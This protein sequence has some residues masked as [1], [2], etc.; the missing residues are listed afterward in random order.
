MNADRRIGIPNKTKVGDFGI[1]GRIFP[2]DS[3]P[4]PSAKA[5]PRCRNAGIPS[6]VK[7]KDRVGRAQA[8]CEEAGVM[9]QS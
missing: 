4:K 1:D 5:N 2:V 8:N 9:T 6:K 7:Q 3:E